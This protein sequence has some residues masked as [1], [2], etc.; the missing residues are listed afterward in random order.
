MNNCNY[1]LLRLF[2]ENVGNHTL[3]CKQQLQ[4]LALAISGIWMYS[5]TVTCF[6]QAEA[7][8]SSS[9]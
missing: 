7:F 6:E 4:Q 8:T 9:L 2:V 3:M 1:H 5:I